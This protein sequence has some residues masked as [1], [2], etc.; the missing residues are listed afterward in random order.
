M[1][2]EKEVNKLMKNLYKMELFLGK[3]AQTENQKYNFFKKEV[4]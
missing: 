1:N 4:L 3:S 2:Y